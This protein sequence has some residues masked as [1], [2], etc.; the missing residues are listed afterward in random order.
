MNLYYCAISVFRCGVYEIFA[1]LGCYPEY[2]DIRRR[3]GQPIVPIFKGQ[4][5]QEEK[6]SIYTV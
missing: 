4:A 2:I 3:F 5:A 6:L 1:L